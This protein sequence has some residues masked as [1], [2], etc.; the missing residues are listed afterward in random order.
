M[1]KGI[2][3]DLDGTLLS[4]DKD[5]CTAINDMRDFF[6]CEPLELD[7]IKSYLGDGIRMLVTRSLPEAYLKYLDDAVELFHAFY[8]SCFNDTTH[9]YDG[10]H[11]T[12][13]KL[14]ADYRLA[15]VSNKAQKYVDQLVKYHFKDIKFDCVYGDDV[16]HKRKPDPQG[17][18]E[19]MNQ[20]GCAK[21]EIILVGDSTVDIETAQRFGIHIC[22]VAWGFQSS[23]LLFQVSHVKPIHSI[24]DLVLFMDQLNYNGEL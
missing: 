4:T 11:E 5:L 14:Q 19:S 2:I 17:I 18:I 15:V 16:N 13:L 9:P 1:I 24:S 8:A 12:L 7:V 10:I 20:M 22:P 21:D 3:F 23:E 6:R